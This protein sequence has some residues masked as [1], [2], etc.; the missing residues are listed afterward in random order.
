MLRRPIGVLVAAAL[1]ATVASAP[2]SSA[3]PRRLS[4]GDLVIKGQRNFKIVAG[5]PTRAPIKITVIDRKHKY[6]SA[7]LVCT[8]GCANRKPQQM[9]HRKNRTDRGWTVARTFQLPAYSD[10]YIKRLQA[11]YPFGARI[12]W[13]VHIRDDYET[14]EYRG[15]VSFSPTFDFLVDFYP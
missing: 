12:T 3:E 1:L 7:V 14:D 13:T 15:T 8:Q 4:D 10:S 2:I 5:R 11:A 9:V 6:E